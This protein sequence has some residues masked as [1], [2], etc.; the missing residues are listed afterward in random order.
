MVDFDVVIVGGGH[1]GCEA[2][3]AAAR[4]GAKS[5]LVTSNIE[6]IGEMSCNPAMGGLGKGH[7][8]REIDALDGVMGKVSDASAIQYR[9]LNRKKGPA[10][11]GPRAQ[12]DRA[13]YKLHMQDAMKHYHGLSIIDGMVQDLHMIENDTVGGVVLEDGS[14]IKARQ[15]IITSGTFLRGVIHLGS[16][17]WEAGRYG[18]R[19]SNALSLRLQNMALPLAR[20]KTGT[21]ARLDGRTINWAQLEKQPGDEEPTYFSFATTK[22]QLPQISCAITYTNVDTHHIIQDHL[23]E[24]AVYSGAIAGKGP[25]YCPSIEDKIVR[26]ADRSAHQIFLEPEGLDNHVVYPN[27]ISTSLGRLAQEKFIHSIEGLQKAEIIR[28]GYAI[29]YDYVDPRALET[30]LAVRGING[31]FLAGQINGTTG[32]EEAAGQGLIAGVNAA[33]K[34]L[35]REPYIAQRTDSYIG[36]MIDDL[37]THGVTEP[38]RMF[39]SRAEY[40]LRLRIDNADQRLTPVGNQLGFVR[41]DRWNAYEKKMTE[42]SSLHKLSKSHSLTPTEAIKL[43]IHVNAD[44]K[45]RSL[46]ELLAYP[47]VTRADVESICPQLCDYDESLREQ[48]AIEA[49]YAGYVSRQD[50]DIKQ[51]KSQE[52]LLIPGDFS[53]HHISGLSSELLEKLQTIRP[54][55]LGQASRIEGMTPAAL[56]LLLVHIRKY[57]HKQTA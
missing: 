12:I 47:N 20:L 37:V 40:R 43:G 42:L 6:T 54:Q 27:G 1:A 29:E 25:R 49:L 10:V 3:A 30:T 53:Y 8:I 9:L 22:T 23:Q 13:Y 31:L 52:R 57:E 34:A 36:V 19:P 55:S 50:A 39:T 14:V 2:A 7:I 33:A 35:S 28:H 15:V 56:T 21:P 38:Y 11:R 41:Q 26:F 45:R 44:G 48:L 17:R 32:Y 4:M 16:E 5:A 18:E 24:S 51:F 46:F